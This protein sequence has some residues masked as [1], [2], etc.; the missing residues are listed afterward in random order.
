MNRLGP[1]A[2]AEFVQHFMNPVLYRLQL[3]AEVFGDFFV[4]RPARD[5][6]DDFTLAQG[7]SID[8]SRKVQVG[9]LVAGAAT[10]ESDK[11]LQDEGAKFIGRRRARELSG[12]RGCQIPDIA[13][14]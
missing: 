3:Q 6:R 4:A 2:G 1:V 14:W 9:W 12:W 8:R 11:H 5:Q 13:L 10:V 7:Q